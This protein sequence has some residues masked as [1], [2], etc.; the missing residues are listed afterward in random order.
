MMRVTGLIP[1]AGTASRFGGLPKFLLPYNN[2]GATLLEFQVNQMLHQV[3]EVVVISRACWMPAIRELGL[4]VTLYES[5][6]STLSAVIKLIGGDIDSD[7]FVLGFPDT[8]YTGENPFKKISEAKDSADLV[9]GCWEIPKLL[10]GQVGQVNIENDFIVDIVDKDINCDFKHMWGTI[11]F[12]QN[13]IDYIDPNNNT[14]GDDVSYVIQ[15][16]NWTV[17]A[18]ILSGEYLDLGDFYRYRNYLLKYT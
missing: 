1:A 12:S 4:P 5:E 8:I 14:I 16:L 7:R 9:L 13:F 18:V 3:N 17:S 10:K 2:T 15:V 11:L 6:P